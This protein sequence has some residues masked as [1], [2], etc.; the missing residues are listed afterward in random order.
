MA[1]NISP[2]AFTPSWNKPSLPMK[3]LSSMTAQPTAHPRSFSL[4][5]SSNQRQNRCRSRRILVPNM[6]PVR[7]SL[8]MPT[9]LP[10]EWIEKQVM[11]KKRTSDVGRRILRSRKDTFI[12]WFAHEELVWRRKNF[13]GYVDTLVSTTCDRQLFL[14]IEASQNLPYSK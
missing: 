8:P 3:S 13:H 1:K 4:Q 14:S 9:L 5:K 2:T 7:S 6:P 10:P 11:I 12:Q